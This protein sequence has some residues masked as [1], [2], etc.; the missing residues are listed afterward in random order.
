MQNKNQGN[1]STT[2]KTST[3][4]TSAGSTSAVYLTSGQFSSTLFD[5]ECK[6]CGDFTQVSDRGLCN[7]QCDKLIPTH[8]PEVQYKRYYKK[9]KDRQNANTKVIINDE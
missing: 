9:V 8:I 4:V 7:W 6:A 3:T 5:Q 2:L 1:F